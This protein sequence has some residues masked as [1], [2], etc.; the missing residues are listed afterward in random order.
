MYYMSIYG[1]AKC[2][3]DDYKFTTNST[4][5]TLVNMTG[6]KRGESFTGPPIGYALDGSKWVTKTPKSIFLDVE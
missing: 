4:L 2:L 1:T 5:C 3:G 6:W